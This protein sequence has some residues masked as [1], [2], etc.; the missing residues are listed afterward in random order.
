MAGVKG[1]SGRRTGSL[2]WHRNPTALAGH[3]LQ[4]LIEAWLAGVPIKVSHDRCLVPPTKRRHTVPPKIKRVLAQVA[5]G[6]VLE[7]YPQWRT[8]VDR[9]LTWVRR[10]APHSTLRRKVSLTMDEREAAYRQY[11]EANAWKGGER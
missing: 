9:V 4:G 1:R 6:H 3:H 7:L 8:D 10:R 2:S 5:L 11:D